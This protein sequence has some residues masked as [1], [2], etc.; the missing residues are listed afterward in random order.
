MAKLGNQ[1]S[2]LALDRGW[3]SI[4]TNEYVGF[5]L[6]TG[7]DGELRTIAAIIE[8]GRASY[9]LTIMTTPGDRRYAL[10]ELIDVSLDEA[11]VQAEQTLEDF[12]WTAHAKH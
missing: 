11:I 2:K 5:A 9:E 1:L 12:G 10:L 6:R 7:F 4:P 8:R 3:Q